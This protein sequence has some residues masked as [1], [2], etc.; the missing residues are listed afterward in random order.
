MT[1]LVDHESDDDNDESDL[2]HDE[3]IDSDRDSDDNCEEHQALDF[4]TVDLSQHTS[5]PL[6]HH[7]LENKKKKTD[8]QMKDFIYEMTI[9]PQ[10]SS[11]SSMNL[12]NY[13]HQLI[14]V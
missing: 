7:A 8:Q 10:P 3:C 1:C 6:C 14:N 12:R 2:D 9:H 11:F 4:N 5:C 13:S